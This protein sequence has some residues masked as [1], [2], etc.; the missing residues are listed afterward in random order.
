MRA[1]PLLVQ[2]ILALT[3]LTGAQ[4]R[5]A[6][7]G[8]RRPATPAKPRIAPLPEARRTDVHRQ[9]EERFPQA[10]ALDAG[11]ST[12]L[13]VPP[14]VEAVMPYT[15]Y[16]SESSTLTARHRELIALRAAWLGN[17]QAVWSTH[18]RRARRQGFTP[19]ELRRIAEGPNASGWTSI[20]ATLLRMSDQLYR[21]SAVNNAVWT[22]LASTYGEHQ[23]MDAV[24]T[25]NHF[26]M[27]SMMYN[28]F[29]VA[30][31]V[32][33]QDRIPTDIAYNVAVDAPEPP[34][35]AARV[36]PLP[37]DGIAVGRTLARH[38]KLN[39]ARARRA[40][41][42]NRLSKLTPRHR[43]MFIL[44]IGWNC[45]SE[46]EWAQHVGS[47]GRARDHGLEPIRIARGADDSGWDE[48]EKAILRAVD[49]LYRD[50][51]I[52]DRTWAVLAERYDTELLM[53]A[54][55][56]ASSYRATSMAL[57]AFGVQLEPGNERFPQLASR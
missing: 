15:I 8:E 52:S 11:F 2:A 5:I 7:P 31:E 30:P 34:L 14:L 6:P 41:F 1:L 29:G 4:V 32:E 26:I 37:G 43:E 57:N 3:V 40:N 47:V 55:F 19:T 46:Y 22:A 9:L 36:Q 25:A 50:A 17:S 48:F 33:V 42:I 23:L 20:E 56:T 51:A 39:E 35:T 45:R 10:A 38:P 21:N 12:L 28:S 54:V 27:L 16:L 53:S 13:H 24:E 44:R 49:E 18:A